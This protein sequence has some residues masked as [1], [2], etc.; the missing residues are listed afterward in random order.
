[1]VKKCYLVFV[2]FCLQA[3][4]LAQG[5]SDFTNSVS[6][7]VIARQPV[8]VKKFDLQQR[9][10]SIPSAASEIKL[11]AK[12]TFFSKENPAPQKSRSAFLKSLVL[13]GWGQY[14]LGAKTSA[15]TFL[16]SEIVLIGTSVGFHVYGNWLE[17]DFSAFAARHAGVQNIDSKSDQFWVDVGNFDSVT[18][19]NDEKLRQ[20]NTR[21]LRD[22]D[23]DEAWQ[24]DSSANRE[25]FE[26]MR[27]RRDRADERSAFMIAGIVANH[28]ISAVH[29]LWL[30]K[31]AGNSSAHK[32]QNVRLVWQNSAQ[33]DGGRLRF[34]YSF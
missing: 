4:V 2:L 18:D 8:L 10:T 15:R 22:L 5:K 6:Q 9:T 24:W 7:P 20:R 29:A 34:F 12:P 28:V 30:N 33:F 26:N 31:K 32:Q 11:L 27:I 21:D 13:P 17:S 16:I 14:A 23:G 1:M 19:F 25:I 3:T